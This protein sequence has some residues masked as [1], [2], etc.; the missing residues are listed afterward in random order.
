MRL[1]SFSNR[2]AASAI[3]SPSSQTA[4]LTPSKQEM[5]QTL[6][7]EIEEAIR[8]LSVNDR[9]V[10]AILED[11]KD[12]AS[13]A[14]NPSAH[15]ALLLWQKYKQIVDDTYR[16]GGLNDDPD[17]DNHH[18]TDDLFL[19]LTSGVTALGLEGIEET[20]QGEDAVK[21]STT[22]VRALTVAVS[23]LALV[24]LIVCKELRYSKL[25]AAEF[26]KNQNECQDLRNDIEG[27]FVLTFYHA[28]MIWGALCCFQNAF[29]IIYSMLPVDQ[30]SGYKL[31]PGLTEIGLA[32]EDARL[33]SARVQHHGKAT[34]FV[35]DGL[36]FVS[37]VICAILASISMESPRK[38]FFVHE[39]TTQ[40][41]TLS[42]FYFTFSRSTACVQGRNPAE[43][44]KS[45]LITVY[46]TLFLVFLSLR[47]SYSAWRKVQRVRRRSVG[48]QEWQNPG[49]LR[50]LFCRFR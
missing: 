46:I 38:F 13:L 2:L 22:R 21:S 47:T 27:S 43:Y 26:F 40:Y 34:E 29:I 11:I 50:R 41:H 9:G 15:Y 16:S 3:I 25:L 48:Y 7:E 35:L 8:T 12:R 18:T 42:T 39:G 6:C 31:I 10:H 32:E 19:R 14:R 28:V 37:G 30:E 33:V 1:N 4:K 49:K 5:L 17:G 44:V 36:T 20:L 24:I 23:F 45:G